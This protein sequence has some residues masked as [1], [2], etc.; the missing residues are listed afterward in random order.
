MDLINDATSWQ[1]HKNQ[2]LG[3]VRVQ[4]F[5]LHWIRLSSLWDMSSR[6]HELLNETEESEFCWYNVV[7]YMQRM[8]SW[9]GENV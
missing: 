6:C 8:E 9:W 4:N 3:A 1:G 2:H 7:L 5:E